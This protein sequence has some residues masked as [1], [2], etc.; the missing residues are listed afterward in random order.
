LKMTEEGEDVRTMMTC[1]IV[2]CP[3]IDGFQESHSCGAGRNGCIGDH[4]GVT[5]GVNPHWDR[6]NPPE[7]TRESPFDN[8]SR[9]GCHICGKARE[10]DG[11]T[12]PI[13][14]ERVG[15]GDG[16]EPCVQVCFRGALLVNPQDM[17]PCEN[18]GGGGPCFYG[19]AAGTGNQAVFNQ[20]NVLCLNNDG[21]EGDD[22][23]GEEGDD[24]DG[25][26]GDD[27][28]GEEG[29]DDDGE[30]GDDPADSDGLLAF[31]KVSGGNEAPPKRE[32]RLARVPCIREE[33]SKPALV[34]GICITHGARK[35]R[36]PLQDRL[37]CSTRKTL[38]LNNKLWH[39]LHEKLVEFKRKNGHCVVPS[40][41]KQDKS[42]GNWVSMQRSHHKNNAIRQFWS[43]R[44]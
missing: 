13:N 35:P 10:N 38:R 22:D 40:I 5:S 12:N 9:N 43:G 37:N 20:C 11:M 25:E 21:E 1:Q 31:C 6:E 3:P 39:Q 4:C 30:E 36:R 33:C 17:P 14:G 42:L 27:D 44:Q 28:D 24:N 16:T 8:Q 32:V 15:H 26:E 2:G 19:G 29:D 18:P 7:M 41:Y 34:N 23:D